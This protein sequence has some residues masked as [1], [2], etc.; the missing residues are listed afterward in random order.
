MLCKT[1]YLYEMYIE[2]LYEMYIE[3]LYEMY[4]ESLYKYNTVDS[5]IK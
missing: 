5:V 2:S 3:S 4:I 1:L